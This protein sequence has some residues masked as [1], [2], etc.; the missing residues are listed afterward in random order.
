MRRRSLTLLG[1]ICLILLLLP[2]NMARAAEPSDLVYIQYNKGSATEIKIKTWEPVSPEGEEGHYHQT[3]TMG[4]FGLEGMP[5]TF[6]AVRYENHFS[7]GDFRPKGFTLL[8]NEYEINGHVDEST[9]K[10]RLES[11]AIPN[12]TIDPPDKEWYFLEPFIGKILDQGFQYN[13]EYSGVV[14][15]FKTLNFSHLGITFLEESEYNMHKVYKVRIE[16]AGLEHIAYIDDKNILYAL[17]TPTLSEEITLFEEQ[18][19]PDIVPCMTSLIPN[20]LLP[21]PQMV[22]MCHLR[23]SWKGH[24]PSPLFFT[25]NRQRESSMEDTEDGGSVTL[26][27]AQDKRDFTG[28]KTLKDFHS[29]LENNEAYLSPTSF[30]ESGDPEIVALAMSIIGEE[31]DAWQVVTKLVNWTYDYLEDSNFPGLF[32]SSNLLK[33]RKGDRSSHMVLFTALA[34]SLSIPTKVVAGVNYDG[35]VFKPHIWNEVWIGEWIAVDPANGNTSPYPLLVKFTEG[36]SEDIIFQ[37][38][39]LK[40]MDL[41]ILEAKK[42]PTSLKSIPHGIYV[43][44]TMNFKLN[45]SPQIWFASKTQ[46]ST[47]SLNLLRR[48]SIFETIY[49]IYEP[50][51]NVI[52][53]ELLIPFLSLTLTKNTYAPLEE[54]TRGTLPLDMDNAFIRYEGKVN[55]ILEMNFII[56]GASLLDGG[57]LFTFI[58]MVPSKYFNDHYKDF[59]DI[60]ESIE[61][62]LE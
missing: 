47:T 39:N 10:I 6:P 16:M 11:K 44:D 42:G 54:V 48:D 15:D 25:D 1:V 36:S 52:T 24:A 21:N 27:I 9:G 40:D 2:W 23:L 35:L 4:L 38:P 5:D 51:G 33:T 60:L 34:R 22:D 37:S 61:T 30:I 26:K 56:E 43:D 19:L 46:S 28:I 7:H 62:P 50:V 20:M 3:L 53:P 14:F 17:E 59:L 8:V 12:I 49:I 45:A 31:T 41:F 13:E 55:P 58:Y 18:E 29:D 32:T 57:R